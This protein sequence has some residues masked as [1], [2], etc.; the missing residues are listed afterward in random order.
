VRAYGSTQ[1]PFRPPLFGI[2]G[3]GTLL[4]IVEDRPGSIDARPCPCPTLPETIATES[5]LSSPPKD[6]ITFGGAPPY[7]AG[8]RGGLFGIAAASRSLLASA[9][10]A[11]KACCF[12]LPFNSL[13]FVRRKSNPKLE[14]RGGCALSDSGSFASGGGEGEAPALG[15]WLADTIFR[16]IG[17]TIGCQAIAGFVGGR[18]A[19]EVRDAVKLFVFAS[20]DGTWREVAQIYELVQLFVFVVVDQ[21]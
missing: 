18:N 19:T 9:S 15:R 20:D 11:A 4:V 6:S 3:M 5:G 17:F 7:S 2:G 1:S 12:L 21:K 8:R 10:R 14:R 16:I 13:D